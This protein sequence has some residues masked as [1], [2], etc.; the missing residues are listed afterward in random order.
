MSCIYILLY[1]SKKNS[2]EYQRKR[3]KPIC[4]PRNEEVKVEVAGT[5]N[6]YYYNRLTNVHIIYYM[7][8]LPI[9][10]KIGTSENIRPP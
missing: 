9:L 5:L 3:N 2:V 4:V 8:A 6:A 1:E 7:N 10:Q